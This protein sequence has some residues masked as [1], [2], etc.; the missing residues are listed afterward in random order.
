MFLI[1]IND[2]HLVLENVVTS[3]DMY[4][5]DTSVYDIQSNM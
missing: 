3:T 1:F 5:D 4:A 2:L